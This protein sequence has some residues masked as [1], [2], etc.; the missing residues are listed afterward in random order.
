MF[1]AIKRLRNPPTGT[2]QVSGGV[3]WDPGPSDSDSKSY[4]LPAAQPCLSLVPGLSSSS[5]ARY[6]LKSYH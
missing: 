2:R 3:D 6:R 1:E 5:E 4:A